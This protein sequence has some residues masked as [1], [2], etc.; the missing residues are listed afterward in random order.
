MIEKAV[1]N[2][3]KVHPEKLQTAKLY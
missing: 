1:L 3:V 2:P